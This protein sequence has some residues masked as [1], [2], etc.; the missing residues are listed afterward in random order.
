MLPLLPLQVIT[1]FLFVPYTVL[2]RMSEP[3]AVGLTLALDSL[4]KQISKLPVP[5]SHKQE[6]EDVYGLCRCCTAILTFVQPFVQEVKNQDT[7]SVATALKAALLK[8]YVLK[9]FLLMPSMSH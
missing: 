9:L 8:L 6:Q 5:Y 7:N 2:L 4:Q 1:H 3:K